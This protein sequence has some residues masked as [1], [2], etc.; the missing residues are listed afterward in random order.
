[1]VRDRLSRRTGLRVVPILIFIAGA[2]VFLGGLLAWD[3][4]WRRR[5]EASRRP[6]PADV[7]AKNLVETIIGAGTVKDVKV[8]ETAG[9][10]EVTFTSATYP[11]AARA[12]V[13]G[14]VTAQGL[15]R[16][17]A[18]MRVSTGEPLIY[19]RTA[20]GAEVLAARAEQTGRVV[21]VL[22]KAG[23]TVEENSAVVLIEPDDKTEARQNLETEGLLAF[24]AITSQLGQITT[25]TSRI[26]YQDT[27]LATVVGRQ[28]QEKVTATYHESLR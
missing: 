18:G 2:M 22:V 24:Q 15:D 20:A 7:V 1:M 28:G 23:D 26:V 6:P 19:V 8:D 13:A 17:L 3:Y 16:L 12:S 5:E 25:V 10:I 11:P 27:T 14:T 4:T 21:Q 9:T